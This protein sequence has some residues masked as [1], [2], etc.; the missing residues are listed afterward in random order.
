MR[1]APD[2]ARGPF[3]LAAS[4]RACPMCLGDLVRETDASGY[5]YICIQCQTKI[6]A[7]GRPVQ[8]PPPAV[9][10]AFTTRIPPVQAA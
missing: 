3:D 6:S 10:S 5:C 8:A 4:V 2:R 9:V 1:Y 7:R